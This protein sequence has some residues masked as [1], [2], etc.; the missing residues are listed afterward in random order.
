MDCK[1]IA[2]FTESELCFAESVHHLL[3]NKTRTLV[4]TPVIVSHQLFFWRMSI[5]HPE[6]LPI[7]TV[8]R[9]TFVE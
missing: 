6:S 7:L 1:R 9:I 3:A 8:A 5:W 2:G 4:I